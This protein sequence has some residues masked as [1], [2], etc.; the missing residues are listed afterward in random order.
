MITQKPKFLSVSEV[1]A[2]LN[3][4]AS[5]IYDHVKEKRYPGIVRI[6]RRILIDETKLDAWLDAGG[7]EGG[8]K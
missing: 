8:N 6:G 4:P 7:D 5:S 3:L 1:A 2:K